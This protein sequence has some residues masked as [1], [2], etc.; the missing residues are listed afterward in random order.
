M[1]RQ[2]TSLP[3][4][5]A[6]VGSSV[7]NL[8]QLSVQMARLQT[9]MFALQKA[10]L[11]ENIDAAKAQYDEATEQFKIAVRIVQ[12]HQQRQS[13]VMNKITQ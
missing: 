1:Y 11:D 5:Q 6:R 7:R 9:K 2:Y 10:I 13:Q 4:L 3:A 8:A 12:E